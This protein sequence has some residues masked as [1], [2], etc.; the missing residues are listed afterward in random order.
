MEDKSFVED[1]LEKAK[2]KI[3]SIISKNEHP[4][5]NKESKKSTAG[6]L[7][8]TAKDMFGDVSTLQP[9]E[10]TPVLADP[11][12]NKTIK[13]EKKVPPPPDELP[14]LN[15]PKPK[16]EVKQNR[17]I[18]EAA[19]I[20][21]MKVF[22]DAI[23]SFQEP[24]VEKQEIQQEI[25][26]EINMF[27]EPKKIDSG[28]FSEFEKFMEGNDA[29][30]LANEVV[31]KDL[32]DKM[33]D[34]HMHRQEGKPYYFH[35]DDL[36]KDMKTKMLELKNLEFDW[37]RH[38]EQLAHEESMLMKKESEMEIKLE[39]LK[40]IMNQIK[41][42][43][44]FHKEIEVKDYFILSNGTALKSLSDLRTGLRM[45][46]ENIFYTHFNYKDNHFAD[47]VKNIF[48]KEKLAHS[49]YQAKSREELIEVLNKFEK[50]SIDEK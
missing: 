47:W 21:D 31:D 37:I 9:E 34:Y 14:S 41:S 15:L 40:H 32:L 11:P 10:S 16:Q 23:M 17:K 36:K 3:T 24:E 28:F 6:E 50:P 26:Q 44:E 42:K 45:M 46:D 1:S 2:S 39:E 12:V 18:I 43:D 29:P 22:E 5:E 13:E 35:S 20:D 4:K 8:D 49:L 30:R 48:G 33:K 38:K 27:E 25:H 19:D 7:P